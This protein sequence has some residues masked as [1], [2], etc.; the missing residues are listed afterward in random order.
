MFDHSPAPPSI[1]R[2]TP[3]SSAATCAA[4]TDTNLTY[5]ADST[6]PPTTNNYA[7]MSVDLFNKL[8]SL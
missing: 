4:H 6:L 8:N 1:E 2:Q 7:S 5:A 3:E